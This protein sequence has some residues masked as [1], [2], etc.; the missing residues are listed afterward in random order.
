MYKFKFIFLEILTKK[1]KTDKVFDLKVLN[2]KLK[3]AADKFLEINKLYCCH[4][5]HKYTKMFEEIFFVDKNYKIFVNL[6][7]SLTN[8]SNHQLELYYPCTLKSSFSNE[9]CQREI[10]FSSDYNKKEFY[11]FVKFFIFFDDF[12]FQIKKDLQD[13]D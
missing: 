6:I 2:K 10:I 9:D 1:K 12:L 11:S 4:S 13:S 8:E 5:H 7:F 3:R